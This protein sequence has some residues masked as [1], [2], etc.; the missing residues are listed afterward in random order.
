MEWNGCHIQHSLQLKFG[1][2]GLWYIEIMFIFTNSDTP[3]DLNN[4][5]AN[6]FSDLES[7]VYCTLLVTRLPFEYEHK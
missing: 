6:K 7:L 5:M 2:V 3:V 1:M 4:L